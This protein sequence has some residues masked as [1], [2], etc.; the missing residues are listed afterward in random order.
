MEQSDLLLE[1]QDVDYFLLKEYQIMRNIIDES[2]SGKD[3]TAQVRIRIN[4][5]V[6]QRK[7]LESCMRVIEQGK[8]SKLYRQIGVELNM[9]SKFFSTEIRYAKRGMPSIL[10]P[11]DV[12][13][14][15]YVTNHS[16]ILKVYHD[17][18]QPLTCHTQGREN[19]NRTRPT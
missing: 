18:L 6:P 4:A 11:D 13:L 3:E 10:N 19:H 1:L 2:P 14:S 16:K 5:L 15:Q 9:I 17:V 8:L 12:R 7:R